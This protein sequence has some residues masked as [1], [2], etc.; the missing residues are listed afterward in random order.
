MMNTLSI[1][2]MSRQELVHALGQYFLIQEL[3][4]KPV[5]DKY[6]QFAW[7]FL[8]TEVLANLLAKR[9]L[10]FNA[11]VTINTWHNGGRFSSR[12]VRSNMSAEMLKHVRANRLYMSGHQLG[13]ALDYDVRGYTAEEARSMIKAR[14][15]LLP[16]PE[17][18]ERDTTWV[19]SDCYND[20]SL[21]KVLF[22]DP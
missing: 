3:V 18:L 8:R 13:A 14:E 11:P 7:H 1:L 10:V 20:G 22:F 9:V 5:Y 4:D 12:G 6:N 15:D 21:T 19:H 16:Y 17:R 2:Q